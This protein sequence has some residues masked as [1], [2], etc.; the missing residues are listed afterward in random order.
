MPGKSAEE[1]FDKIHS[2]QIT[3]LQPPPRSKAC[4]SKVPTFS[5]SSL[6]ASKLLKL[7]GANNKRLSCN[8]RRRQRAH[9]TVRELLQRQCYMKG[10]NEADLFSIFEPNMDLCTQTSQLKVLP[11][12]PTRLQEFRESPKNCHDRISPTQAKRLPNDNDLVSPPVLKQ[13]KNKALH[14]KYIDLLHSRE[15]KRKSAFVG[16][17]KPISGKENREKCEARNIDEIRAAKNAL[18]FGAKQVINEFQCLQANPTS[19]SSDFN[20]DLSA[21][22]DEDEDF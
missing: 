11:V 17:N 13:V 9:K 16:A 12:T 19:S 2:D 8:K 15:A 10:D 14:E 1:C 7:P 21:N 4:K 3:P 18:L 6:S 22:D 5:P 20:D